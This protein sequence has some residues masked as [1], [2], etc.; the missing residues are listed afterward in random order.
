MNDLSYKDAL[1]YDKRTYFSFYFSLLIRCNHLLFFSFLPKF[2]FNSR[3]I[4]MYLFFFNFTTYFF[5]NTL[6]FT[7][8]TISDGFNFIKYF[9]K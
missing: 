2:D 8:E 9:L 5:V 1:R 4:K 3:I 7:D 6:F